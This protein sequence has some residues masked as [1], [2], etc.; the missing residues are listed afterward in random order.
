MSYWWLL[1]FN[2]RRNIF[3]TE[4]LFSLKAYPLIIKK[5]SSNLR[6]LFL[7][8]R[9]FTVFVFPVSDFLGRTVWKT[10]ISI[11]LILIKAK[12]DFKAYFNQC[13]VTSIALFVKILFSQVHYINQNLIPEIFNKFASLS[14]LMVNHFSLFSLLLQIFKL[15]YQANFLLFFV[16]FIDLLF[17]Q[18]ECDFF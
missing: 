12:P 10:L 4:Y 6:L 17:K 16:W 1:F 3:L 18:Y 9:L 5:L 13:I 15:V 11:H 8:N 7:Q 2:W 14:Y